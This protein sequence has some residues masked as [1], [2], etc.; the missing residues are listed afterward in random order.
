MD[1]LRTA[2]SYVLSCFNCQEN[3]MIQRSEPNERS[4]L[5]IDPVSNSPAVRPAADDFA[6]EYPSSLPK[7]D[8]QSALSRIVQETASNIIDVA[9]MD[10]HNLE[11]QEYSDRVKLYSQRLAQQWSTVSHPRTGPRGLLQ[12]IPNPE[13][14]L[15]ATPISAADLH[16]IRSAAQAANA[17]VTE[18]QVEHTEDLIVPFRIA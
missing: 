14:V 1:Y 2:W 7:K 4:H 11:P 13:E 15:S 6:S 16:M 18:I 10:M 5:L 17:A 9:A 8:E 3:H 12:D